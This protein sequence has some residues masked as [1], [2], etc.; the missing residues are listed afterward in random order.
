M[1]GGKG[2]LPFM[3]VERAFSGCFNLYIP[4]E[5]TNSLPEASGDLPLD[6]SK[7]ICAESGCSLLE[8]QF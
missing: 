7:L 4:E 3:M 5:E 6:V 1:G 8:C 2:H